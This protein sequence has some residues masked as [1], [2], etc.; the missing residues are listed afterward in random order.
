[1]KKE[2]IKISCLSP[3]LVETELPEASGMPNF[4]EV[5][6]MNPSLK[7]EDVSNGVLYMLGTPR[8]VLVY[9]LIMKPVGQIN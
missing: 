5:Y 1:M 9:D 7:P 8:H 2:N 3:G 6:K 4:E